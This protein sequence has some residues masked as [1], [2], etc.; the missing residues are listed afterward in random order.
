M[1]QEDAKELSNQIAR[2]E[3]IIEDL[4]TSLPTIR[5]P[6][7]AYGVLLI[8]LEWLRINLEIIRKR[9]GNK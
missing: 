2:I 8:E 3:G 4:R 1:D 9:L 6:H 5:Q 7:T